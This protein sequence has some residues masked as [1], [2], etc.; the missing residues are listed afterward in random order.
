MDNLLF[1]L[2]NK[3]KCAISIKIDCKSKWSS[4][5]R[6]TK[7]Q[8]KDNYILTFLRYSMDAYPLMKY[9][10]SQTLHS[11]RVK[12]WRCIESHIHAHTRFFY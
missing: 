11:E 3:E 8:D 1:S 9:I 12:F 10:F 2:N 5:I 7:S 6:S 4:N